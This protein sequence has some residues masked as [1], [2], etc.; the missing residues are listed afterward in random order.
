MLNKLKSGGANL[1]YYCIAKNL[2]KST[3]P[4]IGKFAKKFRYI[5]CRTMFNHCGKNVNIENNAYIG[6]GK[7]ISIDD[8]SGIGSRFFVQNTNLKIG[9]YVMMGEE[10]MIIGGGHNIDRIDIPMGKQ[11]NL[12]ISNLEI[13][14]DVWI[15][16]RSTI[17]GKVG[18]IGKG[19]IIGAGSVVTKEVPCYAIVAGNP[20]TIIKYRNRV[21]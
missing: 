9:K 18:K 17:L 12:P 4:I 5:L 19:A 11:G 10:I 3:F 15:G 14:D 1:L 2:P 6:N 13:C 20:A 16:S 7:K 8:N 21:I